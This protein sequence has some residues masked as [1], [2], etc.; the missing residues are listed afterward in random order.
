MVKK[1]PTT[2][3][4]YTPAPRVTDPE[5]LRRFELMLKVMT[6]QLSVKA[7]AKQANLSRV[8]FQTLMHRAQ[9]QLLA[10][11]S[12]KPAGRPA[13]SGSLR[14]LET[15][16]RHLEHRTQKL[17]QRMAEQETMLKTASELISGPTLARAIG[18]H[19]APDSTDTNDEDVGHGNTG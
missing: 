9:T 2:R 15:R 7:A 12:P 11:L 18:V 4:A 5:V 19:P 17:E 14:E 1:K 13:K 8:R 3:G 10:E 6:G 16:N